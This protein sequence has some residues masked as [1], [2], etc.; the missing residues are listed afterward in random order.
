V[1][2]VVVQLEYD[3]DSD[4]VDIMPQTTAKTEA[5]PEILEAFLH[6]QIGAG[7]D[8]R[9]PRTKSVYRIKLMLD[10]TDDSFRV[11]HDCGNSGLMCGILMQSL[12]LLGG[13]N[14]RTEADGQG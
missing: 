12:A 10:L 4:H 5:V 6:T 13:G 9:P 11:E 14:G 1:T 2:P 3:I 7:E 8:H